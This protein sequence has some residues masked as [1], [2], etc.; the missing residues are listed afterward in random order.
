MAHDGVQEIMTNWE[1]EIAE[2]RYTAAWN[3]EDTSYELEA[4][5]IPCSAALAGR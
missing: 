3:L 2:W 4:V 1:E 5:L